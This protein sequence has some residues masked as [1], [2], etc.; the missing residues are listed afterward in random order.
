MIFIALLVSI[1]ES[2]EPEDV[3]ALFSDE[4]TFRSG[5]YKYPSP[6]VQ[7]L[8]DLHAFYHEVPMRIRH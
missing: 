8:T 6:D 1:K 7:T 2:L 5:P 4:G 3:P